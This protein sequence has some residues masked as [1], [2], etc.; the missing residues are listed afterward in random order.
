MKMFS[1][2]EEEELRMLENRQTDD[3]SEIDNNV[4][5]LDSYLGFHRLVILC[6]KARSSPQNK[7]TQGRGQRK[8]SDTKFGLIIVKNLD[9]KFKSTCT[10]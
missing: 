3:I 1:G 10:M 5:P 6:V 8:Q 7:D 2:N 9:F 4:L